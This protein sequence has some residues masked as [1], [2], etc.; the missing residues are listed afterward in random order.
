ML[1]GLIPK[2]I[3][4]TAFPKWNN[5]GSSKNLGIWIN[6]HG[7]RDNHILIII[8]GSSQKHNFD[9]VGGF[10]LKDIVVTASPKWYNVGSSKNQDI[11]MN[12]HGFR[13][14]H[15]QPSELW[16]SKHWFLNGSRGQSQILSEGSGRDMYLDECMQSA[17]E[18]GWN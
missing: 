1:V 6:V 4:A 2:D 8:C 7:F 12:V 9:D 10:I 17:R 11:W 15:L 18:N 3:I 16:F 13:D 14:N 5:V